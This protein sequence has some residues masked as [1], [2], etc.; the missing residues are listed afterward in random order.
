[1]PLAQRP[2]DDGV[3]RVVQHVERHVHQLEVLHQQRLLPVRELR[4]GNL[5]L[6]CIV[7]RVV[8]HIDV[9]PGTTVFI[10]GTVFFLLIFIT[11]AVVR[12]G[13]RLQR[14]IRDTPVRGV[15]E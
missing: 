12:V 10:P 7:H 1:M 6:V 5:R 14:T 3:V 11:P 2:V 15:D 9:I 8:V 13:R 4:V